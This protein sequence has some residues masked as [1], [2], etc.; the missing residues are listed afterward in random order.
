MR[1]DVIEDRR[2]GLLV[3][4]L[5]CLDERRLGGVMGQGI[6][7]RES[8]VVEVFVW[9]NNGIV[10]AGAGST[11]VLSE[12]GVG[13]GAAED[14]WTTIRDGRSADVCCRRGV[15]DGAAEDDWNTIRDGMSSRRM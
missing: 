13:D 8:G 10:G 9:V 15:D 2:G 4:S 7:G 1:H 5:F 12:C 11:K 3:V 6:G 14:D